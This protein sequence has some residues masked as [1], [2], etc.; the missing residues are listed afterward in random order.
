MAKV[1]I[2]EFSGLAGHGAQVGS[3]LITQQVVAIGAE[4]DS[5]AFNAAT[6]FI[7]VHA[8][9]ICSITIGASPTATTNM[10]RLAADQT[11]Y[12]GVVGGVDKLSVITNT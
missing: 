2:A 6:A 7:R 10:M 9:A 1:Y 5:A 4:T 3:G 8:D 12:F 11:E